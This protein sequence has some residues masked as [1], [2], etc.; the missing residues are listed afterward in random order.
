MTGPSGPSISV[1]EGAIQVTAPNS[2]PE[3]VAAAVLDR[4]VARFA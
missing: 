3:L 4:L 2:N 1:A